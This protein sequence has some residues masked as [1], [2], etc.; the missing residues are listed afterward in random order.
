MELAA[1]LVLLEIK[2]DLIPWANPPKGNTRGARWFLSVTPQVIRSLGSLKYRINTEPPL[3]LRLLHR[4]KEKVDSGRLG[5]QQHH[6]NLHKIAKRSAMTLDKSNLKLHA[7]LKYYQSSPKSEIFGVE[8]GS[9]AYG[10]PAK[11]RPHYALSVS[12]P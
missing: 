2:F 11:A 4:V 10:F 6:T 3:I 9:S 12:L 1:V 7:A 8:S 5:I